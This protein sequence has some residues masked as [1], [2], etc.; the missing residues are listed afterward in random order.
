[1]RFRTRSAS[2]LLLW[3]GQTR[4]TPAGDF[5]ALGVSAGHLHFRFNLGGGEV[6]IVYNATRVDDG[7]WHRLRAVRR[8]VFKQR[9]EERFG[10]KQWTVDDEIPPRLCDKY[11]QEG[12][13][14]VD[15]SPPVSQRA[16]GNLR[17]LNTH[18]GLYLGGMADIERATLRKYTSGMVGCISD[19]ILDTDYH[20]QLM[21]MSTA[22][23]SIERCG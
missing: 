16:P 3:S 4:M 11:E 23:K 10:A 1:M 21:H 20:V 13:L 18:T 17:Q 22:S 14:T 9:L 8:K 2:G 19:L 5:L 15:S 6:T 12:S 7:L